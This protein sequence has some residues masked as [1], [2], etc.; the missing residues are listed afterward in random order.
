M[1]QQEKNKEKKDLYNRQRC[2]SLATRLENE[3][4]EDLINAA[5]AIES[6]ING[7]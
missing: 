2:V 7:N 5:K 4:V 6:Y 1:T 3:S